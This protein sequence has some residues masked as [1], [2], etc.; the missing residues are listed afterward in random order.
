MKKIQEF[1][2][3][4]FSTNVFV[5]IQQEK[6]LKI[7]N[8]KINLTLSSEYAQY[9]DEFNL[10]GLPVE[11]WIKTLLNNKVLITADQGE[12]LESVVVQGNPESYI[13]QMIEKILN[14]RITE[15]LC[16]TEISVDELENN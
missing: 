16:I 3:K 9:L 12:V 6:T 13:L 14:S 1:Y 8:W 2:Y 15:D 5:A 4:D 7:K 10:D 11:T